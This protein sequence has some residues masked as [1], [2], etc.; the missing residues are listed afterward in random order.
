ME[1]SKKLFRPASRGDILPPLP[2]T[3]PRSSLADAFDRF[4]KNKA[5]V[6]AG[7]I[8]GLLLLFALLTP[9]FSRYSV[10]FRDGFYR[11]MPP[12]FARRTALSG[13]QAVLDYHTAIGAEYGSSAVAA[14]KDRVKNE[15]TGK[16]YYTLSV[17]AYERVGFQ[18][19]DL[20]ER[21]FEAL[22]AYQDET[23]QQVC[24]PLP[25]NYT[26]F[27]LAVVAALWLLRRVLVLSFRLWLRIISL[28]ARSLSPIAVR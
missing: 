12:I 17:D 27:Y 1:L 4:L 28:C 8:I 21:E 20:S 24:Y 19:V 3:K 7:I 26:T 23:G 13:P 10:G 14:V 9:L 6:T 2:K 25:K 22:Q 15:D 16:S 11:T 5:S 18:Y